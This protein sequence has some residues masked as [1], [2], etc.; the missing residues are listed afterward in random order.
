[1]RLTDE[2]I[3]ETYR[4]ISKYHEQHLKQYGVKLPRL[5]GPEGFTKNA[6]VLGYLAEGYPNTQTVTKRQLT[7]FV[8]QHYPDTNDVQQGR[9]LARNGFYIAAGGR[10]NREVE[11]EIGEYKL[12]TLEQPYPGFA[13]HQ[14]SEDADWDTI[15]DAYDHRCATCGSKESE[16]SFH[17]PNTITR[18]QRGH[19]DPNKSLE[20]ENIIPQCEKCNRPDRNNWVYDENG[21]VIKVANGRVITRSD[22]E[23]RLEAYAVLYEEFEGRAPADV[24]R[25]D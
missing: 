11:L 21:R 5:E 20:P 8:R 19:K 23:V 22:Y 17:Y 24:R 12:V 18:L 16:R 2:K 15:K 14:V 9:H 6:L 13:P 10:D 4:I 25:A 1:M 7:G 3:N